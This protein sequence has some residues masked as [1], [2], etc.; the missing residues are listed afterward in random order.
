MAD[1]E[2]GQ[3]ITITTASAPIP[4]ELTI[5]SFNPL[6]NAVSRLPEELR[7]Q[8]NFTPIGGIFYRRNTRMIILGEAMETKGIDDLSYLR[9]MDGEVPEGFGPDSL[10]EG[11]QRFLE[12]PHYDD[13]LVAQVQLNGESVGVFESLRGR[14]SVSVRLEYRNPI[15]AETGVYT[16]NEETILGV[17]AGRHGGIGILE[18][19]NRPEEICLLI[20]K[21]VEGRKVGLGF[22]IHPAES[23]IGIDS[24][25]G[26]S[27][28]LEGFLEKLQSGTSTPLLDKVFSQFDHLM[29]LG[30][31]KFDNE[32]R[33]RLFRMKM[34]AN[35][36]LLEASGDRK[37]QNFQ[38]LYPQIIMDYGKVFWVLP[39][40][41][42]L[43]E[44]GTKVIN[45]MIDDLILP[46]KEEPKPAAVQT[47]EAD[48]HL[49][50]Q[51]L[52]TRFGQMVRGIGGA[53]EDSRFQIGN[54][55]YGYEELNASEFGEDS[56]KM[57]HYLS[58]LAAMIQ[59]AS[60]DGHFRDIEVMLVELSR[61]SFVKCSF[62]YEIDLSN[63]T[64]KIVF[65]N[66]VGTT[67]S[68]R[69]NPNS[70]YGTDLI[71]DLTQ[72]YE[73]R[74]DGV[75]DLGDLLTTDRA[76]QLRT[77]LG[78]D[79]KEVTGGPMRVYLTGLVEFLADASSQEEYDDIYKMIEELRKY[80]NSSMITLDQLLDMQQP[81]GQRIKIRMISG[82]SN[83]SNTS[84][85][86]GMGKFRDR[87][88]TILMEKQNGL[89]K[90]P[91]SPVYPT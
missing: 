4:K 7:D 56:I 16:T 18:G 64:D 31:F 75:E 87:L 41:K 78:K 10:I 27:S 88:K 91:T 32:V 17:F 24:V 43:H 48:P 33:E 62:D 38:T 45:G 35:I 6:A 68:A 44:E 25:H 21:E 15:T 85:Y 50:T 67:S 34:A 11:R 81:K 29:K 3:E 76:M 54:Q 14:P 42:Y 13:I 8:V 61:S 30:R 52:R 84:D 71:K 26:F 12:L 47:R 63:W 36:R 70:R 66:P 74:R 37:V 51:Q 49:Y 1:P 73:D 86:F 20:D 69:L 59:V 28:L 90:P 79:F 83:N 22:F 58:R 46:K 5:A 60:E 2:T 40:P 72:I 80:D 77:S 65:F 39:E 89:Q 55:V 19:E 9:A 53:P 23:Q 82:S 57:R